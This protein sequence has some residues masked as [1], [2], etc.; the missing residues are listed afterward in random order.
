MAIGRKLVVFAVVKP[1]QIVG[2]KKKD[3]D[4]LISVLFEVELHKDF[5]RGIVVSPSKYYTASF[6]QS[7]A[8][9]DAEDPVRG[10]YITQPDRPV[11]KGAVS[12]LARDTENGW[13]MTGGYDGK[14][15]T[16]LPDLGLLQEFDLGSVT[17]FGACYVP[18]TKAFWIATGGPEPAVLDMKTGSDVARYAPLPKGKRGADGQGQGQGQGQGGGGGGASSSSASASSSSLVPVSF[19]PISALG[20]DTTAVSKSSL[21]RLYY[22]PQLAKVVGIADE[23][24]LRCWSFNAHTAECFLRMHTDAV[25]TVFLHYQRD[26][27]RIFSGG[28]DKRLIRWEPLR[29][30]ASF[31]SGEELQSGRHKSTVTAIAVSADGSM[32]V[33]GC[34]D[35]NLVFHSPK[36]NQAALDKDKEKEASKDQAKK[37]LETE[38]LLGIKARGAKKPG[39]RGRNHGGDSSSEDSSPFENI[40]DS[41]FTQR[42]ITNLNQLRKLTVKEEP[43]P[44]FVGALDDDDG[45]SGASLGEDDDEGSGVRRRGA[46][47]AGGE[48]GAARRRGINAAEGLEEAGY[49]DWTTM[50][51]DRLYDMMTGHSRAISGAL[52]VGSMLATCS[53]DKSIR[54]WNLART[55]PRLAHVIEN[56]HDEEILDMT[57]SAERNELATCSSDGLVKIWDFDTRRLVTILAGHGDAAGSGSALAAAAAAAA[58]AASS[59]GTTSGRNL[60]ESSSSKRGRR[61]ATTA[62][63]AGGALAGKREKKHGEVSAIAWNQV[64]G[65]WITGG[66]DRTIRA[67]ATDGA[68]LSIVHVRGGGVTALCV[69][70]K[71][72][73]VVAANNDLRIRIYDP[74]TSEVLRVFVGNTDYVTRILHCPETHNYVSSSNDGTVLVWKGHVVTEEAVSLAA[75]KQELKDRKRARRVA[76]YAKMGLIKDPLGGL[77][78]GR[79]GGGQAA[80]DDGSQDEDEEEDEDEEDLS[81]DSSDEPGYNPFGR[82]GGG[83]PSLRPGGSRVPDRDRPGGREFVLPVP[84]ALSDMTAGIRT[85]LAEDVDFRPKG[86]ADPGAVDKDIR[87]RYL[88]E[89]LSEIAETF[90]ERD[91][92]T[93]RTI[94]KARTSFQP[95]PTMSFQMHKTS[96][97]EKRSADPPRAAAAAAKK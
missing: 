24:S 39:H 55:L 11:H 37:A 20:R 53:W 51:V 78:G 87:T 65:V 7:L 61:A 14:M 6:D 40:F 32:V 17:V 91:A 16:W 30:N 67:W 33:A 88:S 62:A 59:A 10:N 8:V 50:V 95:G 70:Q 72:G 44:E 15:K 83:A 75:K 85:R 13:I 69:D 25:E 38:A 82:T 60:H 18:M 29:L 41:D 76:R 2:Q 90:D 47:G 4:R 57:Y 58:A 92:G 34:E 35:G 22:I 77:G 48:G 81:A 94:S 54:F 43:L 79:R 74:L 93:K 96:T 71:A 23:V 49:T 1:V 46:E 89:R 5:I 3:E 80:A 52:F 86:K 42:N 97:A 19:T 26:K 73:W 12:V 84:K 21:Q 31:Y 63:A 36:L 28:A 9:Y 45:E 68:C 27:L 64:K 56:A 66:E